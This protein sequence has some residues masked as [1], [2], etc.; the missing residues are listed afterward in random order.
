[1][2]KYLQVL[3]VT[4]GGAVAFVLLMVLIAYSWRLALW[5]FGSLALVMKLW[6]RV[7]TYRY[8]PLPKSKAD[9][10]GEIFFVLILLGI[11]LLLGY[12]I[13][14]LLNCPSEYFEITLLKGLVFILF[15]LLY[16][17][18]MDEDY[19]LWSDAIG[20]VVGMVLYIACCIFICIALRSIL[21]LFS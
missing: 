5:I 21:P 4:L 15:S 17:A 16:F 1:M 9:F 18:V 12:G 19:H 13:E 8:A 7:D 20:S 10:I 6:D 2:K 14:W 11:G 3:T